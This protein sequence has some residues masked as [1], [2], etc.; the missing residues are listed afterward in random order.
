MGQT[1]EAQK[2]HSVLCPLYMHVGYVSV[3]YTTLLGT[4]SLLLHA[5]YTLRIRYGCVCDTQC[6]W[7]LVLRGGVL[8]LLCGCMH[9]KSTECFY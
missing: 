1:G 4:V 9:A 5:E 2:A 6:L 3:Q 8:V 7:P